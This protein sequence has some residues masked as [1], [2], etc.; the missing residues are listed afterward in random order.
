[1]PFDIFLL[2]MYPE[3]MYPN[4]WDADGISSEYLECTSIVQ[5]YTTNVDSNG[6]PAYPKCRVTRVL[7][8]TFLSYGKPK[9]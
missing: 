1:M 2:R 5:E 3:R 8:A 6:I 4:V 7:T 9:I